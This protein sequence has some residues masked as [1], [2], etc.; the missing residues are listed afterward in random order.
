MRNIC[1]KA[2][3]TIDNL[4]VCLGATARNTLPYQI[5]DRGYPLDG[6]AGAQTGVL[7]GRTYYKGT[8]D[9]P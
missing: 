7:G 8:S 6:K 9:G 2:I 5:C 4:K 3:R 1:Y